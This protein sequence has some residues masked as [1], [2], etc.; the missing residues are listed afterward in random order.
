MFLFPEYTRPLARGVETASAG[1]IIAYISLGFIINLVMCVSF[2]YFYLRKR[3]NR[4]PSSP[5]YMSATPNP[6]SLV[7]TRNK[8]RKNT[9]STS[10]SILNNIAGTLKSNKNSDYETVTMKRNSQGLHNGHTKGIDL[11]DDKLFC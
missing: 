10:N 3:K 2:Y 9:A 1:F 8:G 4:I 7:P 5:H 6:Y 11:R